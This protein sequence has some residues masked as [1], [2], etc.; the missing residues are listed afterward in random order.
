MNLRDLTE[1]DVDVL[2]EDGTL[3]IKEEEIAKYESEGWYSIDSRQQSR[4][5]TCCITFSGVSV[6]LCLQVLS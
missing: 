6:R 3:R 4:C 2:I 5:C 1:L